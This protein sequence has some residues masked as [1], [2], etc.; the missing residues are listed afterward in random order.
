MIILSNMIK[1]Y[2]IYHTPVTN[3]Y[4]FTNFKLLCVISDIAV[5]IQILQSRILFEEGA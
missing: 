5:A 2:D 1:L 3:A 4:I